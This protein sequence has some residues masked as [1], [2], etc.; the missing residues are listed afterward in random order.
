VLEPDLSVS[1]KPIHNGV[2]VD[3]QEGHVRA[4]EL[5]VDGMCRNS[6]Q[7]EETWMSRRP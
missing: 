2:S 6:Q 7:G 1:G 5:I 3:F 4:V